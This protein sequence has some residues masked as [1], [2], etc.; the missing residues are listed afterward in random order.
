MS[1]NYNKSFKQ[2]LTHI[3][4]TK[5]FIQLRNEI[6]KIDNQLI[7]LIKKRFKIIERIKR[8][9]LA[10]NIPEEDNQKEEEIMKS[11]IDKS[12]LD[13][14]FVKNIFRLIFEESKRFHKRR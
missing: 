5:E 4:M 13:K 10:R 7:L 1:Q 11:K 8:Y 9:R 12:G 14:N 3:N 6:N 2:K